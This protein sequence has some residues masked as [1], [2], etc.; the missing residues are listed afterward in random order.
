MVLKLYNTLS[1]NKEVFKPIDK[2]EVKVY[3]CGP[4]VYWFASVG[5]FRSYVFSDI[6]HRVLK[7]NSYKVN[8]IINVTDV[9]HLTSDS[10]TGDDKIEKADYP[11]RYFCNL[12]GNRSYCNINRCSSIFN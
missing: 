4:T 3:T 8:H 11:T 7:Y 9:G 2:K 5:N 12:V 6:L 10:D 1:K